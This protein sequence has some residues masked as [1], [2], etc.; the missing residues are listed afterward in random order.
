[1]EPRPAEPAW[2]PVKRMLFRFLFAYLFLYIFPFPLDVIPYVGMA[3]VPY[4]N[5]WNAV[6][7]W[8][9]QHAFHV[10]IT[11]QPNGSGDTTYNYVQVFC[12][13]VLALAAA[14]VWT[15]LGRRRP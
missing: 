5:L 10:D 13:L 8:V 11:V 7:P 4:Q 6:V 15:L 14:A 1:M 12:Y 3:T 9:G 2:G